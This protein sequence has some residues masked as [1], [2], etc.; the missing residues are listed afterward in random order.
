MAILKNNSSKII[1][2]RPIVSALSF[3]GINDHISFPT[4]GLPTGNVEISMSVDVNIKRTVDNQV[5]VGYGSLPGGQSIAICV[6][7]GRFFVHFGSGYGVTTNTIFPIGEY[8]VV[9]TKTPGLMSNTKIY[10]NGSLIASS[11]LAGGA[12]DINPNIGLTT[13]LIGKFVQSDSNYPLA[14][15]SDIRIWNRE[16]TSL[17]VTN[18]KT[19]TLG[20]LREFKFTD[21]QGFILTESIGGYNGTLINYTLADVSYGALNKWITKNNSIF[22]GYSKIFNRV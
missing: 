13:G 1:M 2:R 14:D 21:A 6:L 17:E 9:I 5:L 20:L 4:T 8:N 16:L 15:M 18:Y 19:T 22:T 11:L 7:D 12:G 10:V 3:D